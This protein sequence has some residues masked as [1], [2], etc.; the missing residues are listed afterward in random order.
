MS[1]ERQRG[2]RR[3]PHAGMTLGALKAVRLSLMERLKAA[4][5]EEHAATRAVGGWRGMLLSFR[6][7]LWGFLSA[8]ALIL[9]CGGLIVRLTTAL[10]VQNA[11][12]YPVWLLM[13]MMTIGYA[14]SSVICF[15]AA[16]IA[17][18][19][20]DLF[21][22][23]FVVSVALA[24]VLGAILVAGLYVVAGAWLG[25][26]FDRLIAA[27]AISAALLL[28][29]VMI[30]VYY[31]ERL[32]IDP[33]S[34][35]YA[36]DAEKQ[37]LIRLAPL[38][39]SVLADDHQVR[40]RTADDEIVVRRRF[41]DV[42]DLLSDQPG[43]TAHRSAWIRPSAVSALQKR[44]ALGCGYAGRA[45]GARIREPRDRGACGGPARSRRGGEGG[46][47]RSGDGERRVSA[48]LDL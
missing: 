22:R 41:A 36:A 34:D 5:I 30:I 10:Q 26:P 23:R 37:A 32:W 15:V 13:V 2:G 39:D 25:P 38:I 46:Q 45:G 16:V 1:A 7:T 24:A 6:R 28:V 35:V 18:R 21:G 12:H 14:V 33:A 48:T 8:P 11:D 17:G 3:P 47:A 29:A 20:Y 44:T 4:I 31:Q 19:F 9:V 40:I 42:A 43:L 27:H